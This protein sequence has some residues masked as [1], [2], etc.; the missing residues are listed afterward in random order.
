MPQSLIVQA[1]INSFY[2][3]GVQLICLK[4]VS[5]VEGG[6]YLLTTLS[7]VLHTQR[8]LSFCLASAWMYAVMNEDPWG[9][10]S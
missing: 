8:V 7:I 2:N 4:H 10:G 9:K 3:K 6:K 1:V 5:E